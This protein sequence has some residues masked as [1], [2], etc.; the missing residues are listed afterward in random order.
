MGQSKGSITVFRK[1]G[2]KFINYDSRRA[3]DLL[4]QEQGELGLNL[5]Q[6]LTNSEI[7]NFPSAKPQSSLLN[8]DK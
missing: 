3:L 4:D 5:P 6:P 2:S 1:I 7:F 8:L